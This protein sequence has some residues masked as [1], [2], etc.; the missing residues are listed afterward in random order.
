M[1]TIS[2]RIFQKLNEISMTQK[3][4]SEKTGICQSTISEWKK[5]RTNPSSDKIMAICLVLEVTPEWLLSG[6]DPAGS[7]MNRQDFYVI[8]KDSEM[9]KLVCIYNAMNEDFRSRMAGYAE[10]LAGLGR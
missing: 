3:E 2:D 10:A 5:N 8:D 7:R 1:M 6:T 4:F 9:G